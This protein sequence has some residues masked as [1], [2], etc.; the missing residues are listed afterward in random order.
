ME[1]TIING[2]RDFSKEI[3]ALEI[4]REARRFYTD[5][6]NDSFAWFVSPE[7]NPQMSNSEANAKAELLA[8]KQRDM[9]LSKYGDV[10]GIKITLDDYENLE[11]E[12]I[13]L[14]VI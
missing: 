6:F 12:L 9:M 2:K 8:S 3:K 10:D 4:I 13:K 7:H 14:K 11:N 1:P 5:L